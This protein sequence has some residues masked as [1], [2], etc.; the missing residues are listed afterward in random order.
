MQYGHAME[1]AL[2]G[3][4]GQ[5]YPEE[6]SSSRLAPMFAIHDLPKLADQ[7]GFTSDEAEKDLLARYSQIVEWAGRDLS[8]YG[9]WW[10][11]RPPTA[12]SR[13]RDSW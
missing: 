5:L 2:K 12:K 10:R 1:N 4:I 8:G 13:Q 11:F 7:A 9:P 3:L 6:V